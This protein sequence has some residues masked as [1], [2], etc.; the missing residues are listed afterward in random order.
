MA[1]VIVA[2]T[3]LARVLAVLVSLALHALENVIAMEVIATIAQKETESAL[4][5]YFTR[6]EA[7]IVGSQQWVFLLLV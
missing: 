6:G 4:V 1:H 5:I 2:Q 7:A 3:P